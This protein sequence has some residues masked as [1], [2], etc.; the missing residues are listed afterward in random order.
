MH[1]PV[2][3]LKDSLKRESGSKVQHANIQASKMLLDAAGGDLL[4]H[5]L[6]HLRHT[7]TYNQIMRIRYDDD[8]M[9][10]LYCLNV[11]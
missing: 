4:A 10:V 9:L 7:L 5:S 3:V 6:K 1:A 8:R 11:A 2:L